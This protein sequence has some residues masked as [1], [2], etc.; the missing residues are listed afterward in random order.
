MNRL[1]HVFPTLDLFLAG[2]HDKPVDVLTLE[3]RHLIELVK[4]ALNEFH[5][6]RRSLAGNAGYQD[7]VDKCLFW[8]EV[9]GWLKDSEAERITL[10][11]P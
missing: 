6:Q 4:S 10:I 7:A 1:A 5:Q 9:L 2:V 3:R 11:R 8:D